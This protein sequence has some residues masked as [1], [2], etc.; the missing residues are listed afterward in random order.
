MGVGGRA[1]QLPGNLY[2]QCQI[3]QILFPVLLHDHAVD[4]L[5]GSWQAFG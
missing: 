3:D 2:Y 4:Q 5:I 1:R